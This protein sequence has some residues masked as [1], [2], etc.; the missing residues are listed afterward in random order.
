MINKEVGVMLYVDD[1]AAE[2][3]FWQAI[4]CR[5]EEEKEEMGFLNFSMR[6]TLDSSVVFTVYAKDFIRQV[7]PEVLNHQPSLLFESEEL[8]MLHAKI[9]E[10]TD[11]IGPI[12]T[13]PFPNFNFASP[14][15]NYYAVKGV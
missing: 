7:S 1:V 3:E 6:P 9:A 13:E 4:G 11:K 14:S 8:L 2:R 12:Q 10:L 15:G 5:I